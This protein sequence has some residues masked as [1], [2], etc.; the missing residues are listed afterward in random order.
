MRLLTVLAALS[1]LAA[2]AAGAF[3]AHGAATPEAAERLRTGGGYQLAHA[4][5]VFA[6]LTVP[7][8]SARA[9]A[10]LFLLGGAVFGGSLYMLAFTGAR[11]WGAVTPVGGLLLLAG[12][13]ALAWAGAQRA[14]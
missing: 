1:G 8:R 13:A 3:G 10:W 4:L 9:A 2:V 7:G 5:A 12:W 6:A 11:S 14:P